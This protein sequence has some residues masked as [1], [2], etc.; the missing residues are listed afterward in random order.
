MRV[1]K[2]ISDYEFL[3]IRIIIQELMQ[4]DSKVNYYTVILSDV[5]NLI[6]FFIDLRLEDIL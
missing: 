3:E 5:I 1:D 2:L 4:G 6:E